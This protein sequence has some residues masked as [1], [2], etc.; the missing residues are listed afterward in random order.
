MCQVE[1][2]NK[3]LCNVGK[4]A[5]SVEEGCRVIAVIVAVIVAD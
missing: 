2:Y 3:R 4:F 5:G 1:R